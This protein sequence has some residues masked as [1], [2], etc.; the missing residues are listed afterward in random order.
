M[1][2][3]PLIST[4]DA[5]DDVLGAVADA[6]RSWAP[7]VADGR[8]AGILSSR[9]DV[10]LAAGDRLTIFSAPAVRGEL[11]TLLASEIAAEVTPA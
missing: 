9:G 4:E 7:V 6:H 1:V 10:R 5:L 2:N 3:G 8:L 11:E